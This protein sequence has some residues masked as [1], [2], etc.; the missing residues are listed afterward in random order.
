MKL[1]KLVALQSGALLA[2]STIAKADGYFAEDYTGSGAL[3]GALLGGSSDSVANG[4]GGLAGIGS[5]DLSGWEVTGAAGLNLAQGNADTLGYFLQGLATYESDTWEGLIG[6]DY[7]YAENEGVETTDTLRIF[8]QGQRLLTDR[9][10]IGG[11]G[12]YFRDELS[13]LDYRFDVS[14]LFGYHVVKTDRTTLS[15]EAGPG[16]TW[17][18]E[19][20]DRDEHLHVRFGQRFEHQL[21]SRSKIWQSALF[22]P[23]VDDFGDYQLIGEAGIDVLL[24]PNWTLR[25]GLRYV[26]DSTPATGRQSGDLVLTAGL[27]YS[28]GGFP[29]EAPAG[30]ATLKPDAET[31]ADPAK[32]WTTTAAV[33]VSLAKGNADSLAATFAYDTAYRTV[34][35]EWFLT[36]SYL[37][38]ENDGATASDALRVGTRYNR[39]FSD[40]FYGG[41]GVDFLR[42][43]IAEVDYRFTTS[44]VGGYYLFKND[45]ASLALEVGPG[46]VFEDVNGVSDNYFSLRAAERFELVLNPRM[47]FKQASVVDFD[48]NDFDNFI[49]TSTAYLDTD[50]TDNLSWRISATHV[51]DNEPA[52][53]LEESDLTLTTGVAVKF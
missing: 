4:L 43:A 10:Y 53:G 45:R 7:F 50:I 27:A 35:D 47:S 1:T 18:E 42:D 49:V 39:L 36:G 51:F 3:A 17:L 33:G 16:Y 38:G 5:A 29:E 24:S 31:P 30:R 20:G 8:G 23:A 22:V 52:A 19:G 44:L 32:G 28:L 13:D 34:T 40:R 25:S 12:S 11:A 2:A 14:T 37:Y 26:Y 9:F 15:F 41:A 48:V 21:T 6:A 46:Y